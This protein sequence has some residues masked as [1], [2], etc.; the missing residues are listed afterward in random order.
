MS[1]LL[2]RTVSEK[3]NQ[4]TGI[5]V[6]ASVGIH[7][8]LGLTLPSYVPVFSNEAPPT[9]RTVQMLELSEA[10]LSRLP[11]LSVPTI[12]PYIYQQTPLQSPFPPLP[13]LPSQDS[14]DSLPLDG[15]ISVAPPSQ[16]LKIPSSS[17]STRK[18]TRTRI[19]LN[20]PSTP[21]PSMR[22]NLGIPVFPSQRNHLQSS[23]GTT[24]P[25]SRS[26]QTE[27]TQS[28]D[29]R[30]LR[31]LSDRNSALL[32]TPRSKPPEPPKERKQIASNPDSDP[33]ANDDE[34][35][36]NPE[37]TASESD[38]SVALKPNSE[39]QSD[40]TGAEGN[41]V[42]PPP[43]KRRTLI[44]SYPKAACQKQVNGNALYSVVVG[45]D[46]KPTNL[47]LIQRAGDPILEQ[48]AQDTIQ[49]HRF[50]NSTEQ[51]QEYQ[52]S[53]EFSDQDKV[54]PKPT[55]PEASDQTPEGS[56]SPTPQP[57][58]PE[59]SEES[60]TPSSSSSNPDTSD[61]DSENS[62]QP[63]PSETT[64]ESEAQKDQPEESANP[65]EESPEASNPPDVVVPI[66]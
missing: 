51:P 32:T 40:S 6:I 12:P 10:D 66:L 13:P 65:A 7:V 38:Q 34:P 1:N 57:E 27:P 11:D 8:I 35:T 37:E 53:V 19:S 60:N 63:S 42:E 50:L 16:S 18:R 28:I 33:S 20:Q 39:Q 15:N 17:S 14:L 4:P 59:A 46:G 62:G 9:R 3:L 54:C 48:K 26:I 45:T 47:E 58:N 64:S 55:P 31:V 41:K 25:E 29:D 52:V 61:R 5:A 2:F 43:L 30:L 44:A 36:P 23:L 24:N 49:A 22:R 21:F 56:N